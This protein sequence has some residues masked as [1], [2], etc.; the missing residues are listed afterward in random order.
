LSIV[1]TQQILVKGINLTSTIMNKR[2][3][4]EGRKEETLIGGGERR[5]RRR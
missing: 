2:K 3:A 5:E 1:N 4:R